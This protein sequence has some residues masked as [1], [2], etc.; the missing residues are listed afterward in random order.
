VAQYEVSE[1]MELW[2]N[3]VGIMMVVKWLVALYLVSNARLLMEKTGR[4]LP[5]GTWDDL[6]SSSD[7]W[8]PSANLT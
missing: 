5:L 3:S 1:W 4:G 7:G 6:M 2:S 8:L